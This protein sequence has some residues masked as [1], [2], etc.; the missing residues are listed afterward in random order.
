MCI[1]FGNCLKPNTPAN[2]Y[3]PPYLNI[4]LFYF[5]EIIL[6]NSQIEFDLR[7]TFCPVVCLV[8]LVPSLLFFFFLKTAYI[9]HRKIGSLLKGL[10]KQDVDAIKV[11]L[12]INLTLFVFFYIHVYLVSTSLVVFFTFQLIGKC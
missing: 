12:T 7:R 10:G 1:I 11:P 9:M 4:L 3:N 5:I 6:L 2:R 8:V